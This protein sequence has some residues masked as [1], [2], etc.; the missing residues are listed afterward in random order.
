MQ[1]LG[2]LIAST[3]VGWPVPSTE[4]LFVLHVNKCAYINFGEKLMIE[5]IKIL[6]LNFS[7]SLF[8]NRK[9]TGHKN[10]FV[11]GSRFMA[12]SPKDLTVRLS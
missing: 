2:R 6:A 3:G 7:G 8:A 4:G 9:H 11:H 12:S 1:S 10:T 5:I